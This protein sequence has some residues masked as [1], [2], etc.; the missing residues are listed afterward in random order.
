MPESQLFLSAVAQRLDFVVLQDE[1]AIW[2]KQVG[3]HPL[4]V[5]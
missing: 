2:A 4:G 1:I 3:G 5:V